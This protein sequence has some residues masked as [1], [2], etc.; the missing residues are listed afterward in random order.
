MM[1]ENQWPQGPDPYSADPYG[2]T[3]ATTPSAAA[4][5]PATKSDAAKGEAANVAGQA[6]DAAGHVAQTAKAEAA[7]VAG[8]VKTNA[9]DLMRQAK[10]DLTNQAGTQQQKAA[11]GLRSISSQLR[12]MAEAPDRQGVA[13][14][15]VR[16]LAGRS[17]SIASWIGDRD[18]RTVLEE[19]KGFARRRPGTFLLLAAGAGLV[20][21]RLGRS[22]QAGAPV[23]GSDAGALPRQA[24]RQYVPAPTTSAGLP[25]VLPG[26][27]ARDESSFGEPTV[28]VTG[29]AA[30]QTLSGGTSSGDPLRDLDNPSAGEG[31]RQL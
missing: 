19:A 10:S 14:D 8:E 12:S 26:E 1:T 16:Q 13:S 15:A 29:P 23:S 11:E 5:S 21:G 30:P 24:Q 22:L 31:G 2:T 3:P 4:P 9:R 20:A 7:N 28:Q 6:A 25:P 27:T 17:E 18:P